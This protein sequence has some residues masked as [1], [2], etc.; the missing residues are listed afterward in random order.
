MRPRGNPPDG[1]AAARRADDPCLAAD[2]FDIVGRD[3]EHIAGD[4]LEFGPNA[5]GAGGDRADHH[6]GKPVGIVS[7]R[8]RPGAGQGVHLGH[9]M[10]VVGMQAERVGDDLRGDRGVALAGGGGNGAHGHRAGRIERYRRRADPAG[11][12][13]GLGAFLRRL[14][15]GDVGHVRARRLDPA[16][17]AD[18]EQPS[19]HPRGVAPGEEGAVAGEA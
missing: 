7:R 5:I 11:A 1:D 15:Q 8:Q 13:A 18:A 9:D 6:R 19:V 12:P 3:L 14:R 4:A 16:A 17:E 2:Q 10:N